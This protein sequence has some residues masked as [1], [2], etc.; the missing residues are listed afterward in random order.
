MGY[1]QTQRLSLRVE[2]GADQFLN[3]ELD[4]LIP[5]VYTETELFSNSGLEDSKKGDDNVYLC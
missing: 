1:F 5:E 2:S 4:Y 3:W